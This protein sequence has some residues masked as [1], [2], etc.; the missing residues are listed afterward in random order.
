MRLEGPGKTCVGSHVHVRIFNLSKYA[1][2]RGSALHQGL[3]LAWKA[4]EASSQEYKFI[5]SHEDLSSRNFK[6][7][8]KNFDEK[9]FEICSSNLFLRTKLREMLRQIED[10]EKNQ[11]SITTPTSIWCCS[12]LCLNIGL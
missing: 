9:N 11:S 6:F 2:L 3:K 4:F 1:I 7:T 8:L 10:S 12:A 5:F